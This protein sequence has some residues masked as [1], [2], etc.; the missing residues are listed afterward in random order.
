MASPITPTCTMVPPTCGGLQVAGEVV[1]ADDVEHDVDAPAGGELGHRGHEV[2]GPVVDGDI[3]A[4]RPAGLDLAGRGRD[5]H[6]GAHRPADLDGGGAHTRRP[7]VHQGGAPEVSPPC[8]TRASWAVTHTS[9][10]A[11]ASASPTGAG[12][13]SSWRSWVTRRSA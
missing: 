10:M 12:T 2:L 7:G 9:G 13:G 6:P 4:E 8:T 11:A 3:G 1:A 5:D